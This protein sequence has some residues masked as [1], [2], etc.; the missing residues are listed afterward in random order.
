MLSPEEFFEG[1]KCVGKSKEYHSV[2]LDNYKL[3]LI[4]HLNSILFE[5]THTLNSM[6]GEDN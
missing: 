4:G 1:F 5:N 6:S 3:T 2:L